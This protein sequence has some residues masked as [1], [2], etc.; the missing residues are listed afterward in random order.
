MRRYTPEQQQ[1]LSQQ[2]QEDLSGIL[3]GSVRTDDGSRSLFATDASLHQVSPI[4][5]V[6][7]AHEED[8]VTVVRY[9]ADHQITL[10]PRGSGTGLAGGCLGSGIIIDF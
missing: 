4:A 3:E 1:R 8:V 5:V 6:F 7:P 10:I 2:V 9:A